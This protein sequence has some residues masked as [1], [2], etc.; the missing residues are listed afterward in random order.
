MSFLI[1]L[2][3]SN[4]EKSRLVAGPIWLVSDKEEFPSQGWYDYPVVILGWWLEAVVSLMGKKRGIAECLFMDGPYKFEIEARGADNWFI[5]FI[6][7]RP[8]G[9]VR[10]PQ[11]DVAPKVVVSE[12][13]KASRIVADLCRQR[14]WESRDMTTLEGHIEKVDYRIRSAGAVWESQ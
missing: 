6:T 7:D 12:I 9:V 14:N 5:T 10:L 13:L 3:T 4:F 2:R 8:N 1:K 11:N